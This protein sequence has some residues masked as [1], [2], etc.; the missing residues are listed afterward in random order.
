MSEP[1]DPFWVAVD[2]FEKELAT[3]YS[4]DS[5]PFVDF[6]AGR[7]EK[8]RMIELLTVFADWLEENSDNPRHAAGMRVFVSHIGKDAGK[9]KPQDCFDAE[10]LAVWACFRQRRKNE[11]EHVYRARF[12]YPHH[13]DKHAEAFTTI[14]FVMSDAEREH[15]ARWREQREKAQHASVNS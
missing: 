1:E 8:Q 3:C 10:R 14:M 7:W 6:P 2:R 11:P 5:M 9:Y 15:A 13:Q 4:Y 12:R